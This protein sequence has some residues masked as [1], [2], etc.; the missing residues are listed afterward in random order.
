[1]G[2]GAVEGQAPGGE[3]VEHGAR[4]ED[5]GARVDVRALD[6]LGR[7]V[8]GRAEHL[9]RGGHLALVGDVGD[10]EVRELESPLGA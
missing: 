7:H 5:V 2:V 6:L 9:P 4:G 1:V 3:D 10:A 8:R